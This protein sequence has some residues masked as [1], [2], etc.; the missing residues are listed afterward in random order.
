MGTAAI[1]FT[2]WLCVSEGISSCLLTVLHGL[3]HPAY[4]TI[5]DV[6][7]GA[8]SFLQHSTRLKF[9]GMLILVHDQAEQSSSLL[10][11][12]ENCLLLCNPLSVFPLWR[13]LSLDSFE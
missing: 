7:N 13:S 5:L 3:F 9:I 2:L 12:L 10:R 4:Q 6:D 1:N 8:C 11:R